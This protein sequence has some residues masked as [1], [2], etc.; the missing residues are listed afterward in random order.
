[1]AG[2]KHILTLV[3]VFSSVSY[4]LVFDDVIKTKEAVFATFSCGN[5][6]RMILPFITGTCWVVFKKCS[7]NSKFCS[8]S[9]HIRLYPNIRL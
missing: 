9:I 6:T 8:H 5:F 2:K 7:H 3:K 4:S 1:V